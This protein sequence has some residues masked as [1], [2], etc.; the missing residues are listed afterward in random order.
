MKK[1]RTLENVLAEKMKNPEFAREYQALKPKYKAISSVIRARLEVGLTQE[2]LAKKIKTD[3][4][5][6]S[7]FE[8]GRVTPT[9]SFM[10]KIAKALNKELEIGFSSARC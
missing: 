3:Q 5:N 6:I 10:A 8:S 1:Y 2:Q 4:A 9:I 7:R